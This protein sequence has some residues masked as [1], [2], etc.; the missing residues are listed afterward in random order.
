MAL[1][2]KRLK[3]DMLH[4]GLGILILVIL[5]ISAFI[6]HNLVF[7]VYILPCFLGVMFLKG[8]WETY[9]LYKAYKHKK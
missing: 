5:P 2:Q 1:I 7:W 6:Y 4:L 3:Q 9:E 8:L